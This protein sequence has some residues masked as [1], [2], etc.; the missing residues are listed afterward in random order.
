VANN[1]PAFP[2]RHEI[3]PLSLSDLSEV[4]DAFPTLRQLLANQTFQPILTNPKQLDL[5][6]RTATSETTPTESGLARLYWENLVLRGEQ[7]HARAQFLERL[8]KLLP[9]ARNRTSN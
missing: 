8:A 9:A 1:V 3:P 6:I 7:R 5:V 2:V 4:A